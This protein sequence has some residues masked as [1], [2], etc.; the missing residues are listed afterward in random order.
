MTTVVLADDQE[1]VRAGF[2]LILTLA[3]IEVVGEASDGAQ[4]VSITRSTSPDVVLMDVRMPV[5]NGI[6]ATER[7]IQAGSQSRVL[8][9]TTFDLDELV[10]DA[11]R[12]G[13]SG[14][15]LKD[16]PRE[17]L[18]AGIHQ[19]ARGETLLA[20][21]ITR[22]LLERF[23][24][25]PSSPGTQPS[26]PLSARELEVLGLIAKGMSNVE[27]GRVLYVTEATVKTHVARLLAKLGVR[28]RLQAVVWAYDNGIFPT[29]HKASG[30]AE[31]KG[32]QFEG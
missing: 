19:V 23:T 31:W 30:D 7:I 14:F 4:A 28:D 8:I 13:A 24:V 22:R 16:A 18:V 3:D 9:L 5:M 26:S 20:P 11:V 15:L 27:I 32:T 2:R 29:H 10:Y 1:L 17:Q 12:A 6:E 21:S 25:P